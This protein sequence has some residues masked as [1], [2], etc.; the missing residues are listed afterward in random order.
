MELGAMAKFT[1][2]Q[3]SERRCYHRLLIIEP[4][5]RWASL[6][7][8]PSGPEEYDWQRFFRHISKSRS[9]ETE[10]KLFSHISNS[11][12]L[13]AYQKQFYR[14][15]W[16]KKEQEVGNKQKGNDQELT[17]SHPIS[18][19]NT[20]RERRTHTEFDKHSQKTSTVNRLNSSFK[21]RWSFSYPNW[22]L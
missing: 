1:M 14:A 5:N 21:N 7:K 17:Q 8:D 11:Q 19:L 2:K 20:K 13:L 22:K 3:V 4:S 12:S 16:N 6:Q 9:H 15:H 18:P 10:T